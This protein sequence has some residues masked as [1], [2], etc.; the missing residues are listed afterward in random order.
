MERRKISPAGFTLI[1]VCI[2]IFI[3]GIMMT[4]AVIL[5]NN[6]LKQS[7][8][9]TTQARLRDIDSAIVQYLNING[10]LPCPA[11]LSAPQGSFKF[12][13]Q[14]T[15]TGPGLY[16]PAADCKAAVA[17][18]PGGTFK[19]TGRG[20]PA[21]ANPAG[22]IVM[23]AVPVSTLGLPDPEAIDAWGDRFVYAVTNALTVASKYNQALGS[24]YIKDENGKDVAVLNGAAGTAQYVIVSYGPDRAGAYTAAGKH[25]GTACPAG[26]LET[27]NCTYPSSTFRET[28]LNSDQTG[29][30]GM[31]DDYV[32]FHTQ[33]DAAGVVSSGL[34]AAFDTAPYNTP[35]APP[36]C[37]AAWSPYSGP[38]CSVTPL[39]AYASPLAYDY[40]CCKKN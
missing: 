26:A 31:Y 19:T 1:E 28:M 11:D 40:I 2:V 4:S 27:F 17:N 5:F 39:D 34:I 23:G 35:P 9:S 18:A 14:I 29:T 8:I 7:R 36:P 21:S 33:V 24:I 38:A 15:E 16:P 6:Y 25:S 22:N 13:R 10:M 20:I 3:S 32:I 12:G 37:P 30:A